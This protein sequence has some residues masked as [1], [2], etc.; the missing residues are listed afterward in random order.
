MYSTTCRSGS[1]ARSECSVGAVDLP[2]MSTESAM[3]TCARTS[4]AEKAR[5]S[6]RRSAAQHAHRGSRRPRDDPARS[7]EGQPRACGAWRREVHPTRG[8]P[9]LRSPLP[10]PAP[11]DG[12]RITSM[13]PVAT[14]KRGGRGTC[15]FLH[16]FGSGAGV[17][18]PRDWRS[19]PFPA[20]ENECRRVVRCVG[21]GCKRNSGAGVG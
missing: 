9:A 6:S 4:P 3:T 18:Q 12:V 16:R 19:R 5:W 11:V 7:P 21:R 1:A 14:Y 8:R 10:Y 13:P 2:S 17:L 20:R 15:A